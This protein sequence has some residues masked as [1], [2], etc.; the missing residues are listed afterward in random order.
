MAHYLFHRVFKGV[1]ESRFITLQRVRPQVSMHIEHGFLITHIFTK[2]PESLKILIM[3][4]TEQNVF[5][6]LAFES[7]LIDF[8]G[9]NI[10]NIQGAE[11]V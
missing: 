3:L 8:E 2:K 1:K 11:K 4:F 10:N 9:F 6:P 7:G 5:P